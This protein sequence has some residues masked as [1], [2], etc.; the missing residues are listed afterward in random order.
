MVPED[1]FRN[2][3]NRTP[4]TCVLNW[5]VVSD[6]PFLHMQSDIG[7]NLLYPQISVSV[8]AVSASLSLVPDP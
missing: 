3:M 4:V 5:L 1:T 7:P 2:K 8:Q 6:A